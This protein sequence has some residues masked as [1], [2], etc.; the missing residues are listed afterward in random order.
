LQREQRTLADQYGATQVEPLEAGE[1]REAADA[2][3]AHLHTLGR[4]WVAAW[5]LGVAAWTRVRYSL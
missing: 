5:I 1:L 3:V 4:H 2:L